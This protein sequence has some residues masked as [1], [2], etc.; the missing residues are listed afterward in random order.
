MFGS[1]LNLVAFTLFACLPLG[2]LRITDDLFCIG[3][4]LDRAIKSDGDI[5]QV[6]DGHSAVMAVN[7]ADGLSSVSDT[8]EEVLHVVTRSFALIQC[9]EE[10]GRAHV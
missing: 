1:D 10:I 4:P 6:A 8:F 3:I 2:G 5:C 9:F 7:I